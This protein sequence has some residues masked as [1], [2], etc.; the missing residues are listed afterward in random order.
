LDGISLGVVILAAGAS[1]RM[2]RPKMLLPWGKTSVLGHTLRQWEQLRA[3]QITVVCAAGN[4]EIRDELD[5]LQFSDVNRIFNDDPDRGMFSSIRCAAAWPGW[6]PGLDHWAISLGDQPQVR[7]E[8][9][10]AILDFAS[11][12][13]DKICQPLRNGRRRHP[14]LLPES[15]FRALSEFRGS[16][17]KQF[18]EQSASEFKG[19]ESDDDG[20]DFDLDTPADF[21]RAR[22]L[23]PGK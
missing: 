11:M 14:V 15:A 3:S 17:L 19:F 12:N 6:N 7:M 13:P 20:L 18:L 1:R 21:D 4:Q 22:Q 10:K 23:Y 5:R 2:G 9:L 8:T 16:D